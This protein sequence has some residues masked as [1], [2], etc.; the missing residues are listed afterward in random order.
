MAVSFCTTFRRRNENRD[1]ETKMAKVQK[2]NRYSADAV[3][4]RKTCS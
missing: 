1:E 2:S 3:D 4:F